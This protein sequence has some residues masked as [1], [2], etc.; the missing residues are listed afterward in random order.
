M[1]V[2]FVCHSNLATGGTELLHQLSSCLTNYG[3]E[4]YMVYPNADGIHCP[5]PPSFMKY[6]VKYV[7]RYIDSPDSILILAETQVHLISE[8]QKGTAMI[9]WLSVNNYLLSY[10]DRITEDNIDVFNLKERPNLVHFVQS[11]YAQDFVNTFFNPTNC[12]FLMDYINDDIV[13][14]ANTHKDSYSRKNICLY[15][16]KKGYDTLEPIIAA[17]RKD[18]TWIPLINMTPTQM[19]DTMCH[20]K[21][22]I[23]FGTHPGKDRI[24]REAA[25]CGCC[26]LTNQEGSAAYQNDVNIPERYKLEYPQ[27]I[28]ATLDVI[29]ELVDNYDSHIAEYAPYRESILLE[30]D[31][32]FADAKKA[33]L[34]ML[35]KAAEKKA[36]IPDLDLTPHPQILDS[37]GSASLKIRDLTDC[38][39]NAC[40]SND[41]SALMDHLLNIDYILQVMRE[42]IYA[43]LEDIM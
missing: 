15:N 19:A 16:P 8:C 6:N 41:A 17:C 37:I 24:P 25:V 39:K 11:Y 42:T 36:T 31:A 43:E 18:I 12:H 22:Y 29:Y 10:Q 14:W 33:G 1:R 20:A 40:G 27:D 21:L 3:I 34:L 26:I 23:D 9:W 4:N 2:Y 28:N 35:E 38:A 32:F 13:A 7:S 30:K 5:T